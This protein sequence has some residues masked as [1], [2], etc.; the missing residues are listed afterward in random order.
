MISTSHF[1]PMLVHFPIALIIFGF[2]ADFAALLFKKEA[3]LAKCGYYLLLFGTISA[4]L[5]WL[6][7]M[8][9]TSEMSGTA[10]EMRE[11][12]ELFATITL[13]LLILTSV[14]RIFLQIKKLEKATLNWI[15]FVLYGLAAISVCITGYFGGNLV[16]VYMMPI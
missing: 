4:I 6:T 2:L 5:S 14:F 3:Y 11:T 12:H 13:S 8:L 9:F 16:Y 15:A 7:G 10:G 1:H